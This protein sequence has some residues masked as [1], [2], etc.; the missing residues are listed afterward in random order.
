MSE[1]R[2]AKALAEWYR[3]DRRWTRE[4]IERM[5]KALVAESE[6]VAL[7]VWYDNVNGWLDNPANAELVD[8]DRR[9]MAR[10]RNA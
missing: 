7:R 1:D 2:A 4:E 10:I 3:A 9:A 6:D 5:G 8:R